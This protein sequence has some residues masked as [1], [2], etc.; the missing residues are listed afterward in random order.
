MN[1]ILRE[2]LLHFLFLGGLLFF[3]YEL[4]SDQFSSGDAPRQ[5]I[6]ITS[7]QVDALITGFEKT[8]QRLPSPAELDGIVEFTIREEVLYRE[9]LAMGL[10]RNDGIIRRRLKQKIEFLT[11]DIATIRVPTDSELET[12]LRDNPETFRED[13]SYSFHQVFIN[14]DTRG[15]SAIAYANDLL[16]QLQSADLDTRAIEATGDQLRMLATSFENIDENGVRRTLGSL[17]L[18]GLQEIEVGS[19]QGPIRSGFGMHLIY[20]DSIIAREAPELESVRAAVVSEWTLEQQRLM[21]EEVYANLRAK[22]TIT[23]DTDLAGSAAPTVQ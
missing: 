20:L 13:A 22:Y 3:A 10:D 1:K 2:P 21:N 8:W 6:V 16:A 15:E 23:L 17:F 12:F 4:V 5:E 18:E 9:A 7:G 11:D 14:S 19:W